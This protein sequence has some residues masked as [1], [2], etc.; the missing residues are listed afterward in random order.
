MPWSEL[1]KPARRDDEPLPWWSPALGRGLVAAGALGMLLAFVALPLARTEGALEMGGAML[2]LALFGSPKL[3]LIPAG[4]AAL[5]AMLM[6]RRT[7][8]ALRRARAAA[9]IAAL[10]PLAAGA[11]AVHGARLAVARIAAREGAHAVVVLGAGAYVLT[12]CALLSCAG[13]L[14]LGGRP[15]RS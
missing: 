13:A 7:P 2:K 6:R 8:L 9:L 12:A 4:A 5:L 1:P 14:R 15:R 10:V 3:W 11:W